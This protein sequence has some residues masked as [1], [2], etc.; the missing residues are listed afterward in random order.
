MLLY[1]PLLILPRTELG[2]DDFRQ[3]PMTCKNV[4]EAKTALTG[5]DNLLSNNL[6]DLAPH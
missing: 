5:P 2:R 6:L 4:L 3:E 1:L